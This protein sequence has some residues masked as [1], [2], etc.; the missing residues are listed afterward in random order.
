MRVR[1][2]AAAPGTVRP[3]LF[4]GKGFRVV[5]FNRIQRNPC[6]PPV[7]SNQHQ[8]IDIE[9]GAFPNAVAVNRSVS[10][11]NPQR[12]DYQLGSRPLKVRE[13]R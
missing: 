12:P 7:G 5:G 4:S 13:W 2:V 11:G 10:D 1:R 6:R 8:M 9:I 3:A